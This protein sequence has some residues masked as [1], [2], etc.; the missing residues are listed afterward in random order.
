M[1]Q[2]KWRRHPES[3]QGIT[4]LRAAALSLGYAALKER[5]WIGLALELQKKKFRA[6]SGY[7]YG[8]LNLHKHADYLTLGFG[9]QYDQTKSRSF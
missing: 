4:A 3:N 2:K 9:C 5:M 8:L 6:L 7:K 1:R